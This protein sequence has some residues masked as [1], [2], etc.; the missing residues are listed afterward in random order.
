[1]ALAYEPVVLRNETGQRFRYWVPGDSFPH[2]L[3]HGEERSVQLESLTFLP[4]R[5][6]VATSTSQGDH[7]VS[8][9]LPG[10][11]DRIWHLPVNRVGSWVVPLSPTPSNVQVKALF[12]VQFRAGE[13]SA[14]K[15]ATLQSNV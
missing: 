11:W 6:D 10:G 7:T 1:M 12:S 5:E 2:T 9:E 14:T 8:I 13:S 3:E 4:D 15:V